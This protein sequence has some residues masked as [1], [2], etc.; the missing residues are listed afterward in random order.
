MV[1]NK[2]E[3]MRLAMSTHVAGKPSLTMSAANGKKTD[4]VAV[5]PTP[6]VLSTIPK[7]AATNFWEWSRKLDKAQGDWYADARVS[8]PSRCDNVQN[9]LH[10][11]LN[12]SLIHPV[13]ARP[14]TSRD[15]A[16]MVKLFIRVLFP[17][18]PAPDL[19]EDPQEIW[20]HRLFVGGIG[21]VIWA[22]AGSSAWPEDEENELCKL[23]WHSVQ[24]LFAVSN[25]TQVTVDIIDDVAG[26]TGPELPPVTPKSSKKGSKGKKGVQLPDSDWVQSDGWSVVRSRDISLGRQ[27]DWLS[28]VIR[29]AGTRAAASTF[30]LPRLARRWVGGAGQQVEDGLLCGI[31]RTGHEHMIWARPGEHSERLWQVEPLST[32]PLLWLAAVHTK[33]SDRE[34]QFGE[35]IGYLVTQCP[36]RRLPNGG[37]VHEK[38][39]QKWAGSD[40]DNK[41]VMVC[42]D[43]GKDSR[44]EKHKKDKED[45]P[46]KRRRS[47]STCT[48]SRSPSRSRSRSS[49]SKSDVSSASRST[50][51]LSRRTIIDLV[52]ETMQK[53]AVPVKTEQPDQLLADEL[54]ACAARES[55][56]RLQLQ[57]VCLVFGMQHD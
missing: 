43:K 40:A 53:C 44:K 51:S 11:A 38:E 5:Q 41:Y 33:V 9:F 1:K 29:K 35:Y 2:Q 34:L 8:I 14:I 17:H 10:D 25:V 52:N 22:I 32:V 55:L 16:D 6:T 31:L 26:D 36:S 15:T 37:V 46:R 19:V 4:G 42:N 57:Q 28:R 56:L 23:V 30:D 18:V 12:K 21:A 50:M 48:S 7:Q 49:R 39:V 13:T 27:G 45:K 47:T 3:R 24:P 54:V 20:T